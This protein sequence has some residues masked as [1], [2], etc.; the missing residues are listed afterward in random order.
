MRA[1]DCGPEV[2]DEQRM[3]TTDARSDR[4][5]PEWAVYE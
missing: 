4:L 2:L 1:G 3:Q 5:G